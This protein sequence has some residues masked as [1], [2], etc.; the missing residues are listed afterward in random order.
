MTRNPKAD[1]WNGSRG[2]GKHEAL[3]PH[4]KKV[5]QKEAKYLSFMI[6]KL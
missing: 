6:S 1:W 3:V 5:L 4:T 2:T